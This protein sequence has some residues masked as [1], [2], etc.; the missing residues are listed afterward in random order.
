MP[1]KTPLPLH[2]GGASSGA[3]AARPG[4]GGGLAKADACQGSGNGECSVDTL[5]TST[6]MESNMSLPF[7]T[8]HALL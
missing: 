8:V 6:T 3:L 4:Q 7:K 2:V 5:L 1:L